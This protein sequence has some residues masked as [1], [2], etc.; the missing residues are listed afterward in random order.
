LNPIV[1]AIEACETAGEVFNALTR[2]FGWLHRTRNDFVAFGPMKIESTRDIVAWRSALREAAR[3]RQ[4]AHKSL[5]DLAY[6]AEA[7]SAA[8]RRLEALGRHQSSN[9]ACYLAA[10]ISSHRPSRMA[11][12]TNKSTWGQMKLDRVR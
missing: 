1:A 10:E 12:L 7:L 3:R 8:W 2:F 5:E 11:T 9:P 4:R 6:I